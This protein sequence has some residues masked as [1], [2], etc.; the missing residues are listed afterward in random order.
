MRSI[1]AL[2]PIRK[3]PLT[4]ETCFARRACGESML[5]EADRPN[6]SGDERAAWGE[7]ELTVRANDRGDAG[8]D[9]GVLGDGGSSSG[10][11]SSCATRGLVDWHMT[12]LRRFGSVSRFFS[13]KPTDREA[14]GLGG[15]WL[16]GCPLGRPGQ[17]QATHPHSHLRH[18]SS[19]KSEQYQEGVPA[20]RGHS[21]QQCVGVPVTPLNKPHHRGSYVHGATTADL[22]SNPAFRVGNIVCFTSLSAFLD[23]VRIWAV[24]CVG[25]Q[26][27]LRSPEPLGTT[28]PRWPRG[29]ISAARTP[30]A[31]FTAWFPGTA[32]ASTPSSNGPYRETTP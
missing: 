20:P 2:R 25:A 7:S 19:G 16:R 1:S 29:S 22:D 28:G 10:C 24:P 32:E 12:Y 30:R 11:G 17:H 9:A 3:V 23:G 14:Q 6:D 4:V 18:C 31:I 21:A 8:G 5:T 26:K 27:L 15:P 13:R